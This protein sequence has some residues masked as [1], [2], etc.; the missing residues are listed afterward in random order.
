MLDRALRGL[1]AGFAESPET[2]LND[3]YLIVNAVD[4]LAPGA[5][6]YH[7]DRQALELLKAGDFR[8]TAGYLAACRR[9]ICDSVP[10]DKA[11]SVLV[12]TATLGVTS[13][14]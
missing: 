12:K 1:N 5:Y 7:R 11:V 13:L 6:V 3:A 8:T 2:L 9:G 14:T 4:G 10:T